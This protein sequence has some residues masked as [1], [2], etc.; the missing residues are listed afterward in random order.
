MHHAAYSRSIHISIP[1]RIHNFPSIVTSSVSIFDYSQT[2][3]KQYHQSSNNNALLDFFSHLLQ[4]C[5]TI[6]HC[7]QI[8]THVTVTSSFSSAF[9]AARLISV[10]ARFGYLCD[11]QKVFDTT[12]FEC[13][14][15]FILWNSIL[16]ANVSHEC[17]EN[18]IKLYVRM[19]KIGTLGDGFTF[20]LVIR[21]CAYMGSF[22]LGK[23]IH[24]HV[25][26]MGF[27]SHLHV[28]NELIGMYAKLGR[29]RDARHLFDR[30]SVRSYISWN[31]MVSAYAFNYDCN[32]AL[33]IFQR[34]ESEG[35]E[36][37]LVTWTSLI[38]SYARSG[39]HEEAMELFGL[40]RM[41]G[42]EVSGEA[43]AVVI[44]ICAD[45]GAFVRAKIIHEY[46]VKGGFEE[47]SF[48]KSALICVYGKHGD[49]NGAWNLFLEMKNKSLASWNALITSHAEAGLCDEALEIFSQLERSGDCP[50]LR[51]NVVSWS[52]I[53][54]GFASKG[55]EKE[56][57][58]LFRRMQ[59]AKIL[60]NAVTIST[61]LSLCAELAALHLGRE[62]HGHVVR[63]VMVNN[64]LVGNG[65]VNMYAKCGCL[66]EGHMIFEKTERKDLISWNSM[67]TGYGMHGLG[68]NALETFDQM[69]KLGFKPDGVTFVA[70]LS[71]CSHSG[72]VP[73]GR[74][75]FDQMLKKYRI[76]PQ[77]EHYACMVDLLG[78]AGLLREASEIVKNM[79]VAPNACVWG[80]L[81]NSC[82]MHNNTEIAEETAS[83]LF[84]LSHRET[85]GTYMLLSNIYAAS[86]RWED[87][88]RV[89]TS[90]KTKG[91]KKNPGQSWIK[92]EKNVYTFS[93]GNNMQRGF[94]QIFEILEE[95]TFQMERE[96]T[97]HDT[98][99]TPQ[100]VYQE[101]RLT[102][103]V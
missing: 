44:S 25:L 26:E 102:M 66:K 8:H 103:R 14:S 97:V 78:R 65:L 9:L 16:R 23:T 51:P 60:A 41:K 95:L 6:Q 85:T 76:E 30:M 94:E 81:L 49:V 5:T 50:R 34:M 62:I 48:V 10:Y 7:Q 79:P 42:V 54:D 28:G 100:A 56:A 15:N 33:E 32:G 4:Q 73:E 70:V 37:N 46:A 38:S 96:G 68:M 75:L 2:H 17:Y 18:T 3:F 86:G 98:D 92:V 43:L 84:N 89:R 55:R 53:I 12:P 45:L 29:M 80:A 71:S 40:M 58:E 72:L 64:I 61:V 88:A 69:I 59:H 13:R 74:R 57:L 67:I 52:A 101:T 93:A 36:P 21:A 82:R 11:A 39:W 87:S 1:L 20:P 24:G 35:M 77:M 83:H 90:A 19:R 47:Y 22:I 99:I 63:A 27:Q 31:T 91:L